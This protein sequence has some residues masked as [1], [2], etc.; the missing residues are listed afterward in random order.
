[1]WDATQRQQEM[2]A[3]IQ[4]RADYIQEAYGD[5]ALTAETEDPHYYD[6]VDL[7]LSQKDKQATVYLVRN[8]FQID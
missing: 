5:T 7:K 8:I 2:D 3:E 4:G 6:E 1:M